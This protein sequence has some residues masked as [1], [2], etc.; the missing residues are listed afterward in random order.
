MNTTSF[1]AQ[2]LV[3]I[4]LISTKTIALATMRV[5]SRPSKS[6]ARSNLSSLGLYGFIRKKLPV[7]TTDRH[8]QSWRAGL[9]IRC[10][11]TEVTPYDFRDASSR[12]EFQI[13]GFCQNCQDEIFGGHEKPE[14]ST[15]DA[16]E[17]IPF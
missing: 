15:E 1:F 7:R 14:I 5:I 16:D 10:R 6:R 8:T 12:R 11:C 4:A 13:S 2:T 3:S 9:C 17:D